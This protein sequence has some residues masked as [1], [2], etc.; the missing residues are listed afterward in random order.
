[1]SSIIINHLRGI[2]DYSYLELGIGNCINF[3]SIKSKNKMSVDI[4]PNIAMFH[5]TTDEYFAQLPADVRF[6][7]VFID[8]NHTYEY[9]VKDFNNS[10]D[11]ANHWILLHDMFPPDEGAAHPALCG[12]AYKVLYHMLKYTNFTVYPMINNYGFTLV[13]LPATKIELSEETKNLPY[14]EFRAFMADK[15]LYDDSE[16]ASMLQNS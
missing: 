12:D 11:H 2:E 7:I 10:I 5:G 1:M 15:K 3:N 4:V 14:A 16:I 13:K 9:V 6:D 8:A